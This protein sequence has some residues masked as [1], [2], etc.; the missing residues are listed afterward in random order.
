M[1]DLLDALLVGEVAEAGHLL[2]DVRLF[3]RQ[4]RR[5]PAEVLDVAGQPLALL[6]LQLPLHL[7]QAVEGRRRLCEPLVVGVGRR[8][9][10]RVGRL[11]QTPRRLHHLGRL[12]LARQPLEP[13]G[14][15]F[16]LVGED[17]L[18]R[19]PGGPRGLSAPRPAALPLGFL[20]LPARQLAKPLHQRV[21][22]VVAG[23]LLP[24]LHRL[25]LVLQLV[26]FELE[27]VREVLGR[28][29]A[30]A[31][32]PAAPAALLDADLVVG[33]LG[34]LQLLQGALL[35]RQR[36]VDIL[37]LERGLGHPHLFRGPR[38]D[39][40]NRAERGVGGHDAAVHPPHQG[41]DLL[42][43]PPL[44]QRQEDDVLAE[45][46]VGERV[47]IADDVERRR[48]HLPLR[49][50]QG[51]GVAA[52]PAATAPAALRLRR[53]EVAPE[54]PDLDEVEVALDD[55]AGVALVVSGAAVVR[56]E[57]AGL[58]IELF[59]EQG[60]PGRHLPQP[61]LFGVEQLD[62][63]LRPPVDGP[64]QAE[65]PHPEVVVGAGFQKHFL[66][67]VGGGVAPGLDEHDR[68][69]LVGEHVDGVARRR[70][71]QFAARPLQ[72]DLVEAVLF[73]R[74]GGGQHPVLADAQVGGGGLVEHQ[75]PRR[76]AHGREHPHEDLGAPQHGDVAAVLD[77]ARL[78]PGVGGEV[79]LQLQA[80]D[81]GQV[82]DVDGVRLRAHARRIDVVVG[83]LADVE[84]H[85]LEGAEG[86]RAAGEGV[87]GNQ[88][89]RLPRGL[90]GAPHEQVDVAG[91]EPEELRGHR[92]VGPAGDGDV[93]RLDRDAVGAG[94][95]EI[96]AGRHQRRRAVL[97]IGR[98]EDE[99]E[100]GGGGNQGQPA[101][102]SPNLLPLDRRLQIEVLA[103]LDRRAH[104]P[105]DEGGRIVGALGAV[106]PLRL[107]Q[108]AQQARVE[109]RLVLFKVERH[110]LV[111]HP[112]GQGPDQVPERQPGQGQPRQGAERDDRP[113]REPEEFEAVRRH[114]ER[115]ETGRQH[116]RETA[117]G[118]AHAPPVPYAADDADQV[119]RAA[120]RPPVAQHGCP[121]PYPRT[122][123]DA[124]LTP[125]PRPILQ[126]SD[127][128]ANSRSGAGAATPSPGADARDRLL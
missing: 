23:L 86:R 54:R 68:G 124:H 38:Q 50:G 77:Q 35:G 60:V 108:G 87:L 57:V 21:D 47:P 84:Q 59:E 72:F 40:E 28:G 32:A 123:L 16:R 112:P 7:A 33:L 53:A 18:R 42:A 22:F 66:D 56:D 74:E 13:P 99:R 109:R 88:R 122:G 10:H 15:F 1:H 11:L 89:N 125:N 93:A 106:A 24:A 80:V 105:L 27:Q 91:L 64:G 76:G 94:L 30:A 71:H 36:G 73:D 103:A 115:G 14:R 110:P 26:E 65:R 61:A 19:P 8:L 4:I 34:P 20:L 75:P 31:A 63:L 70:L 97:Q 43:Q 25:V 81:V 111:G 62:R 82:D 113:R 12:L 121:L 96:A 48:D 120:R 44:G 114:E 45:L 98:S 85:R 55:P 79:V 41:L 104:E 69:R 101:R 126:S 52:A 39:R 117:Q 107:F 95:V 6:P 67:G 49:L 78:K 29:L 128:P 100:E 46:L 118:D 102:R 51:A 9:A 116:D 37:L 3:R 90:G 83:L 2:G 92:E 17:A 5:P 119:V 127:G 58:Q